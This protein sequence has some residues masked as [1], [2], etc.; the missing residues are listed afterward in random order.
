MKIRLLLKATVD[1]WHI[2]IRVIWLLRTCFVIDSML[3]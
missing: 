1:T 2:E 3:S